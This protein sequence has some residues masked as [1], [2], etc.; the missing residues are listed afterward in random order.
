MSVIKPIAEAALPT[1]YGVFLVHIYRAEGSSREHTVLTMGSPGPGPVL[2]RLHSQCLT[3]DT[4]MSLKCDCG[5][6]LEE[7]LRRIEAAGSGI[8]IYLAQEGRGIGLSSKIKAYALQD[9]G[10]DTV[11]A[12]VHLGYP[13]DARDYK[14]AADILRSLGVSEIILLTNNPDK[15]RQL[16]AHGITVQTVRSIEIAPNDFN[17][18]YLKTKK[19]K[20]G[21]RLRLV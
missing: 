1:R 7:S 8:L 10:L 21:H 4:F 3:G 9:S 19:Q 12:N 6:E 11:E 18:D 2:T 13:A 5:E 16:T 14:L 15:E 20:L 17:R